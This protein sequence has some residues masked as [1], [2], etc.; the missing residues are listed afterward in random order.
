MTKIIFLLISMII[1]IAFLYG[2]SEAKV[3]ISTGA[4]ATIQ[5]EDGSPTGKPST[6]KY[7]N[8]ALTDNGDGTF[9]VAAGGGSG[10]VQ[11]VNTGTGLTGGPVTGSGTISVAANGITPVQILNIDQLDAELAIGLGAVATADAAIALGSSANG[12]QAN[13]VAVGQTA[14]TVGIGAIAIGWESIA[15]GQDSVA[16]GKNANSNLDRGVSIG[17]IIISKWC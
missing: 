12:S 17:F 5:E 16:M 8:G 9:S 3:G 15:T 1:T 7:A 14:R 2:S 10:T 4:R 6:I 13:S 11:S